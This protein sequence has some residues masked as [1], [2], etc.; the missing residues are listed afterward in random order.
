MR[1]KKQRPRTDIFYLKME[2]TFV[3]DVGWMSFSDMYAP[4]FL[5]RYRKDQFKN[6]NQIRCLKIR[7]LEKAHSSPFAKMKKKKNTNNTIH[8][9]LLVKMT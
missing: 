3:E 1:M 7:D 4:M 6:I 9:E 8:L 5:A 2:N